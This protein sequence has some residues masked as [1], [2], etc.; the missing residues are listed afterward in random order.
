[1]RSWGD[2]PGRFAEKYN[3]AREAAIKE[4]PERGTCGQELEWNLLDAEMRPLQKVGA[5]PAQR[6]F[7]DVLRADYLPEWMAD[8]NQLEVFHWM[9]EWATRPYYSPQGA[10]YESRLLEASL[11]NALAQAGR[12]FSQRLYAMHGNLLGEVH[13]DHNSIPG[14]WNLAKRRYLER[15]VDLYGEALATAGNHANL[16]LPEPLLAW[17][18]LH[19]SESERGESHLDD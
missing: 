11:L 13:V 17:D 10:V 19:L 6:S 3:L 4:L 2:E 16:S 7:I 12:K 14:G 9:T 5:G 1:M 18:F 15:C 8:R